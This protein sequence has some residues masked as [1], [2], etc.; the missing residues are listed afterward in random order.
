MATN[1]S[2]SVTLTLT[3]DVTLTESF[4]AA[5]NTA[6]PAQIE[7]KRLASGNNTIN[8]PGPVTGFTAVAVV[9]IPPS[10]NSTAIT[11]KGVAGD[12]GVRVHNTDPTVIALDSSVASFVLNAGAQIDGVRLIWI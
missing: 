3:G 10:G 12:T 1:A 4:A 11:F 7:I 6:S 8:V 9:I 5:V 2:R